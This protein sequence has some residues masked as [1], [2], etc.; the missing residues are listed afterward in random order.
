MDGCFSLPDQQMESD[1][2]PQLFQEFL[3]DSSKLRTPDQLIIAQ[4]QL[5]ASSCL[6]SFHV[7]AFHLLM[8]SIFLLLRLLL[9][10][11][12]RH[13]HRACTYL[14]SGQ[15]ELEFLSFPTQLV[16]SCNRKT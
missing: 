13:L 9:A 4:P 5:Q 16:G 1:R 2:S 8:M 14:V 15:H 7:E 6:C 12:I 3:L 10:G 11:Q